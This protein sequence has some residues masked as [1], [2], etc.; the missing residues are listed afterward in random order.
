MTGQL[1]TGGR[2][3]TETVL[4][5]MDTNPQIRREIEEGFYE[6]RTHYAPTD[7]TKEDSDREFWDGIDPANGVCPACFTYRAASGGCNC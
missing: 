1:I 7:W 5:L 4:S 2:Q 3:F 6:I